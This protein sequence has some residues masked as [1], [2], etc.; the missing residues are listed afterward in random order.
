MEYLGARGTMIHGKNLKSKI[1]CQTPFSMVDAIHFP[2]K[3]F[4]MLMLRLLFCTKDTVFTYIL[5]IWISVVF[6]RNIHYPFNI[7][8]LFFCYKLE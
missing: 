7:P 1:S 2:R 3:W 8:I 4:N 6:F 5:W